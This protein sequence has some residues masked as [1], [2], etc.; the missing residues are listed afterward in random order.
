ME[1]FQCRVRTI[2]IPIFSST[3]LPPEISYLLSLGHKHILSPS[4]FFPAAQNADTAHLNV[5]ASLAAFVRL[6]K[7]KYYFRKAADNPDDPSRLYRV[8]NPN[9]RV[10]EE[11]QDI[12]LNN[13]LTLFKSTI[14]E[15]SFFASRTLPHSYNSYSDY[16]KRIVQRWLIE[17]DIILRLADKNLGLVVL[18]RS[19]YIAECL[20]QLTDPS[21]Y[22]ELFFDDVLQESTF[23]ANLKTRAIN[24]VDSSCDHPELSDDLCQIY[25]PLLPEYMH[26]FIMDGFTRCA[27]DFGTFYGL[28]KIHKVS[29]LHPLPPLRPITSNIHC[30]TQSISAALHRWLTP[31][32]THGATYVKNSFEVVNLLEKVVLPSDQPIAIVA[33]DVVS[34]YPSIPIDEAIRMISTYLHALAYSFGCTHNDVDLIIALLTFVLNNAYLKFG[35]RVFKQIKGVAMG[36]SVAVCFACIFMIV[37]ETPWLNRWKDKIIFM[38]RF[39][40][41]GL[42]ILSATLAEATTIMESFNNLNS[43]IK[44]TYEISTD[45]AI[46]LDLTAYRSGSRIFVRPYAKP[47]NTYRYLHF[48]SFH[49]KNIQKGWVYSNLC[50]YCKL[51]TELCHFL[52]IKQL[53]KA[54]L[55]LRGYPPSFLQPIFDSVQHHQRAEL[56]TPSVPAN[57]DSTATPAFVIE[58]SN[59]TDALRLPQLLSAHWPPA[60][61]PAAPSI[62][63]LH[64][65]P[66]PHVAQRLPPNIGSFV[67]H[68]NVAHHR[69]HLEADLLRENQE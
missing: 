41:D 28:P 7:I 22:T 18:D 3:R 36:T 38:K 33:Y 68:T 35:Q 25:G 4:S 59:F 67:T 61:N 12:E 51:S 57:D 44:I 5:C 1:N 58:R 27:N 20:K 43:S 46:F 52:E 39:I 19:W 56:L 9:W 54:R 65:L 63:W 26:K 45:L 50:R 30:I 48:S 16:C 6:I 49:Q 66:T 64:A 42:L 24:L 40:D 21:T 69:R 60:G 8:A 14:R 62:Q 34:L 13:S 17:H 15:F 55:L 29:A 11:H 53:F 32:M 47:F 2:D 10:P 23:L 37:L 31:F